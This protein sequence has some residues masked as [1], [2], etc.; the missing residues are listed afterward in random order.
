M[1]DGYVR[2]TV[3]TRRNDERLNSHNRVML[4]NWRA[5][6][7]LQVI[8]D[9]EA[10]ARY[11]TKYAAKGEPRSAAMGEIFKKCVDKLN[12]QSTSA[13]A[14]RK[15]MIGAV[16]ERDISAQE[17]A[18]LLLS[19]PLNSCTY[20]F[21]CVSLDGSRPICCNTH[22]DSEDS[23]GTSPS[24]LDLYASRTQAN[25]DDPVRELNFIQFAQKYSIVN[26]ELRKRSTKV[27]VRIFPSF[28]PNPQSPNYG[29]YCKYQLIKFKPWSNFPAN[30]WNGE[31]NTEQTNE[32]YISAYQRFLEMDTVQNYMPNYTV[33]LGRVQQFL[34]NEEQS[35]DDDEPQTHEDQE[36]WAQLCQLHQSFDI[37]N[38]NDADVD[39]SLSANLLPQDIL[40]ECP[41][42]IP[43][44][45]Q[46]AREQ[47]SLSTSRLP[48]EVDPSCF[49]TQQ[50]IAYETINQHY[51]AYTSGYKPLPLHMIIYGTAGTGKSFLIRAMA[52]LLGSACLLTGTTGIA[53]F[54]ICGITLH[55][56]LQLPL[57][58][59]SGKDLQGQALYRL[60]QRLQNVQYLII[61]EISMLGQR[62]LFWVDRRLRQA[63]GNL[64][65][66]LGGLSVIMIGDFG[67][68]PPVGDKPLYTEDTPTTQTQAKHTVYKQFTKVVILKQILRQNGSSDDVVRFR[69]LLLRLR[70]GETTM[71]DWNLLLTRTPT[72]VSNKSSF[73]EATYL[74]YD[75]VSV[76]SFNI[77]RLKT[78]GQPIARVNALHSHRAA[79]TAKSEDAGGL[80]PVLFI[81]EGAKVM[82]TCN[83]W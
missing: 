47:P 35:D 29:Q 14:I 69:E 74:Y 80:E 51:T 21:V 10:C 82:L 23:S 26:G 70:N 77:D 17:T 36:E 33:E 48:D 52:Q 31:Q 9:V 65:V 60:Q 15:A 62:L 11:I 42:W 7:D 75:K 18:H 37:V 83:L 78:I 64:N 59:S 24:L 4:Q 73:T 57:Q 27:I 72:N 32:Y 79:A 25:T 20:S 41:T 39:W 30:A 5:N 6:V 40:L 49:N 1:L 53:G 34:S 44:Q 63:T 13:A 19:E 81:A 68:L 54:N 67:Q 55:S 46:A 38:Q 16:G 45:R 28:S 58:F 43:T 3:V 66:C 12:D 56:A 8:I 22:K 76:T 71:E 61:D 2:T 50:H